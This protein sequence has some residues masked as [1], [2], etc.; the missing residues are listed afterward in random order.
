MEIAA[1]LLSAGRGKRLLPLTRLLPKPA[2]PVLD[3]PLAA[4]GLRALRSLGPI[5]VNLGHL[6]DAARAALEPHAHG[7]VEFLVEAPEPYGTAGTLAALRDRLA[8]TVVTWNADVVTD[9]DVAA[10]VALQR[11]AGAAATL[12]V[13]SVRRGADLRVE[14]GRAV[15]FFDRRQSDAPGARFLGVAALGRAALA[16]LPPSPPAGLAEAVLRPLAATAEL[17]VLE[18]EGYWIDAGTPETYLRLSLDALAGRAPWPRPPGRVL[19][20]GTGRAYLG[21]GAEASEGALGPGAMMLARSRAAPTARVERA[22]V[23]PGETVPSGA[24]VRDA[25]IAGGELV[26]AASGRRCS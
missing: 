26:T 15:A 18:H 14:G 21:P 1:V 16:L 4:F 3:V 25:I 23:W 10:L 12:A 7:G 24:T 5:V 6:A 11:R 22:L 20:V 8:E 19:E 9:L 13:A 2:L 17:A